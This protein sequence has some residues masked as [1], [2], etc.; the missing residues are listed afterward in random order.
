M[1]LKHISDIMDKIKGY[2]KSS[3]TLIIGVSVN[4]ELKEE[5]VSVFLY[6]KHVEVGI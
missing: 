2:F 3:L 6:C 5:L 1:K 4:P